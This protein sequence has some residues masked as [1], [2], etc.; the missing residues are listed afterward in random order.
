MK[1]KLSAGLL[2]IAMLTASLSVPGCATFAQPVPDTPEA[3]VIRDVRNATILY[4]AAVTT[5][6]S[7]VAGDVITDQNVIDSLETIRKRC[8][9][10]LVAAR[11]AAEAGAVIDS[12]TRLQLFM[13]DLNALNEI[14]LKIKAGSKTAPVYLALLNQDHFAGVSKMVEL[15]SVANQLN[16]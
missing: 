15:D 10:H 13:D 14:I 5:F 3:K 9:D 8:W 1:T 16:Y 7:L 11:A 12:A 4:V 6:N 2:L